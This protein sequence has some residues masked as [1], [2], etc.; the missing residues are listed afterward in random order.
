MEEARTEAATPRKLARARQRGILARSTDLTAA[1][2]LLTLLGM[3][4]GFGDRLGAALTALMRTALASA[5]M[6]TGPQPTALL[7]SV[8]EVAVLVG[9]ALAAVTLAVA[10]VAFLQVGPLFAHRAIA[11]DAERLDPL[12]RLRDLFTL[13]RWLDVALTVLKFV[14]L[15]AVA[16][17]VLW[18]ALRGLLGMAS[19]TVTRSA[20]VLFAIGIDL[21]LRIALAAAL[22][23]ALDLA[24][25]RFRHAQQMRM[26]RRELAEEARETYGH[27]ELR[28]RRRR[29]QHEAS[30]AAALA[31]L[32]QANV[33]LLDGASKAVALTFDVADIAQHAPRI[34]AK[35]QGKAVV[36]LQA[37]A[38]R[39]G[40]PTR[41]EP[42]LVSVL[43]R[44]ELTEQIPPPQYAAV[45]DVWRELRAAP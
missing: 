40:I 7:A 27:P 42:A 39:A 2:G 28:E 23:G 14:A 43:F 9:G 36:R 44:L 30:I 11:P 25:R 41:L 19:G 32:Q 16:A 24:Y 13:D 34:A 6:P 10:L 26:S 20:G 31:D 5:A 21:A 45:A 18:P 1:A 4:I 35:A 8:R 3:L 15:L 33:L 29:L 37:E 38:E 12:A 17:L 22:L